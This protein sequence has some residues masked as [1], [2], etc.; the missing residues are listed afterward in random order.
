[1]DITPENLDAT[2]NAYRVKYDQAFENQRVW[3]QELAEVVPSTAD[4]EIYAYLDRVPK[5]REWLGP[6]EVHDLAAQTYELENKLFELTVK[7]A[8]QRIED[9]QIGLYNSQVSRMG[10]QAKKWPDHLLKS[11]LQAGKTVPTY[12]GRNFFAANHYVNPAKKSGSQ[13]NLFTS[14]ALTYDNYVSVKQSMMALLGADGEPLEDFGED[15]VL[16]VDPSNEEIAKQILTSDA[17]IRSAAQSGSGSLF[18]AVKNTQAGTAKPLV[19]PALANEAGTWYLADRSGS[20]PLI[21]QMRYA[22]DFVPRYNPSDPNVF[23]RDE[24]EYGIRARG[25]AGYGL[26]WKIARC[27]P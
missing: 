9:N 10:Q 13:A 7:V 11:A 17:V 5:L 22:P 14:K 27:E 20:M 1:M 16:V 26:W 25:A 18:G 3:H 6:R 4:K 15:L 12:D 21:F 23:E 19:I 2:F 8:R 24:F